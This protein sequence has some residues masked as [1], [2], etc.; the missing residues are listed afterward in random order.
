MHSEEWHE[1]KAISQFLD[2]IG[3]W[4]FK[5]T[6]MGFGGSG[7]P[8]IIFCYLG[9]FGSI[10]VKREG[11]GPTKLQDKRMEQIK[12]AK[13]AAF[14]GTA[15][16]VIPELRVWIIAVQTLECALSTPTKR[17]SQSGI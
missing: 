7:V 14:W 17:R 2:S 8:D 3:A 10:E 13:G 5:P 16:K 4:H 11:K 15:D 1:K 6:T 9:Y 12:L